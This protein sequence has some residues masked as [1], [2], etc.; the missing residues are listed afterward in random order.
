MPK[1]EKSKG[2]KMKG[3]TYP[4]ESPI[5]QDRPNFRAKAILESGK[6]IFDTSEREGFLKGN[7]EDK[8]SII[9]KP[10]DLAASKDTIAAGNK[11]FLESARN[12]YVKSLAKDFKVK[13]KSISNMSA[14]E[15]SKATSRS[16]E[17]VAA[18]RG[19]L[20]EYGDGDIST[21]RKRLD[22]NI[23]FNKDVI[24]GKKALKTASKYAP[25][26]TS[27]QR[28]KTKGTLKKTSPKNVNLRRKK[29]T[30]PFFGSKI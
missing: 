18:H 19:V 30:D 15:L 13:N 11:R 17:R 6:N 12:P 20:E 16:A 23:K 7:I 4:G 8:K 26:M 9:N 3:Y 10:S 21:A 2:F 29:A 24:K 1:F 5:R 25:K 22:R 28:K 14:S 27:E